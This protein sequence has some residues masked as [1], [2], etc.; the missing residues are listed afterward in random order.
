MAGTV[1][2]TAFA[3]MVFV[4]MVKPGRMLIPKIK[5]VGMPD[6]STFFGRVRKTNVVG[7]AA[8]IQTIFIVSVQER[9]LPELFAPSP[10]LWKPKLKVL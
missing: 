7:Y 3:L 6:S 1:I 5:K 9:A 10:T 8:D 2:G 4:Q